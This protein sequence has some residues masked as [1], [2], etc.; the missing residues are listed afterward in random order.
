M[1]GYDYQNKNAL[2]VDERL[3][4]NLLPVGS[5]FQVCGAA[6]AKACLQPADRRTILNI[7]SLAWYCSYT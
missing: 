3:T 4:V 1:S 6:T 5:L 2:V 7:A